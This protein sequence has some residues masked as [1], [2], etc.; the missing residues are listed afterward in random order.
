MIMELIIQATTCHST[1]SSLSLGEELEYERYKEKWGFHF[2]QKEL[3]MLTTQ[4]L[5]VLPMYLYLKHFLNTDVKYVVLLLKWFK[6][7]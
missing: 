3:P 5:K 4:K 7:L 6:Y 1:F 2:K